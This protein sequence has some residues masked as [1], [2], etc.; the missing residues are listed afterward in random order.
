MENKLIVSSSP[1][2]KSAESIR[3]VM[4]D[5]LVALFPAV[6][7]AII[8]FGFRALITIVLCML[9]SML[10]EAI[11]LRKK[12]IFG[13]GSAAVT[14]LLLAMTLPPAPPWWLCIIGGVVA[15]GIGKQAFG[16]LGNNIFNPALVARAVLMIS[17]T[18]HMTSWLS[19]V[20]LVSAATPLASAGTPDFVKLFVGSV[21]GSLG[22]T[23][24]FALLLGAIWLFYKGHINWRIPGGYI[25]VVF[26]M[27]TLL[28]GEG[29]SLSAGLF[30]VLAGGVVLGA[31]FMATDMVTS[32]V[33]PK[34]QLIFGIG[35]G[36]MT[37][38]VRFYGSYPEGVTFAI[39]LMN[40]VTPLIDN[41]TLP[42]KYGEVAK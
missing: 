5:V 40:A 10:T 9:S 27:G 26:V 19:P 7:A 29:I 23:S 12:D 30:H 17:W 39:L 13:D 11:I 2:L 36:L 35:C 14:G 34:G 37:M 41:L 8:F 4:T 18:G 16:G 38:L 31:F 33:T 28:G 21:A 24:A 25:L 42:R 32:P 15:I 22:E 20:D 6:L 3:S 1:H